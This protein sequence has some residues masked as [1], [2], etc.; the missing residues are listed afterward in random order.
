MAKCLWGEIYMIKLILWD[1]DGTLLNFPEAEKAGIRKCFELFRLGECTDEM[2]AAYSAI[3]VRWW[4][5]LERGEKTK[6]EILVG[7]FTEFFSTCGIDP[8]LA[9]PFNDEYQMRLGDTAVFYPGAYETVKALNG[10][11]LQCIVSNG[12]KTAQYKKLSIS[13][14]MPLMDRLFISDEIGFEKPTKEFFAPVFAAYPDI[15]PDE[16]LIVGDSLTSD[17]QGGVNVGIKTCRFNPD[18]KENKS[19]LTPDYEIRSIAEVLEIAD[20]G[21]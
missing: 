11:L 12:T 3:N 18:G 13:G 8:A 16:M 14:L 19:G 1:V 7:R 20:I 6:P 17:I 10:K 21:F 9:V 2:L 5:T 15:K 4:E